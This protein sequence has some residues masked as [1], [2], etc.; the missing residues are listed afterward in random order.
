MGV[1]ISLFSRIFRILIIRYLTILDIFSVRILWLSIG[2]ILAILSSNLIKSRLF[3]WWWLVVTLVLGF[4]SS[5]LFYFYLFFELRLIPILL[6]ILRRG[7]QPER[8]SAGSYLLFYTTFI[9]VPYLTIII[10]IDMSEIIIKLQRFSWSFRGFTLILLIPFLIKMPLFGVHFWLPKAHVEAR[11]SGS[12]VLAG[13]LLKLGRYGAGRIVGIFNIRISTSWFSTIWIFLALLSRMLTFLQRDLKKLVA[14]RRVTHITFMLVGILTSSKITMIRI[15]LVS[16]SHGW[17]AI[18]LFARAGT[19]RHSTSSRL[20]TLVGSES[21]LFW[22][23]IIIGIVLVSNAGIP[24]IPSFFPEVFIVIRSLTSGG[25]SVILFL[26]LRLLVCYYNAYL[27]LWIS[28]M[29]TRILV[30]GK[31]YFV[32]GFVLLILVLIRIESLLWLQIF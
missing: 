19:L 32:E 9:S 31:I 7:R 14:Y 6:I 3:L 13:I 27:F 10:I 21:S 5:S 1:R 4:S 23:I 15:V 17:A 24:P 30:R 8:L 2:V 25:Y 29:K 12:I 26:G 22:V 28:H 11:T 20:G 16:L 18:A